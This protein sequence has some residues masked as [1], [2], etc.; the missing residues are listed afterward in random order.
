MLAYSC[1]QVSR[2]LI[3]ALG[4]WCFTQPAF[5]HVK[6]FND[7]YC[8]TC[9]PPQLTSVFDGLWVLLLICFL[10]LTL[11]AFIFDR[12]YLDK[13]NEWTERKLRL[14]RAPPEDYLR[15]GLG[16]FLVCLWW[17][18]GILLTPELHTNNKLVPWLQLAL[19][20]TTISWTTTWVACVGLFFL[21]C[22]ALKEYGVFHLLD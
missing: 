1:G 4:V 11:S 18:S 12:A 2:I 5:A 19:A 9:T 22:F 21:Y 3:C 13:T 14:L 15:V 16:I 20:F 10:L 17:N 6:W 8:V 7:E